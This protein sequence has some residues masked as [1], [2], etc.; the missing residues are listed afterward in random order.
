MSGMM[1]MKAA[2]GVVPWMANTT[3]VTDK[4]LILSHCT[5]AFDLVNEIKLE[6]H[7]E[8]D[9]SLAING[10]VIASDV[11]VFRLSGLLDEA[12]IAEGKVAGHP[13]LENACRTQTEIELPARALALLRENPL[14]NH[15]LM[16][17]GKYAELL[18]MACVYKSIS[19]L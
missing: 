15:L 18:S 14:G 13:A 17:P 6:T 9:S 4:T 19:V 16:A 5:A 3:R 8:T 11:T 12:F 2:T 7:Y 1:L 10:T